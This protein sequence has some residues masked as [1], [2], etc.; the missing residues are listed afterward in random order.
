M[1]EFDSVIPPGG[2]G[3]VVAKVRTRSL[4]GRRTKS[5]RVQTND[6]A[7]SML[8]LQLSINV[9]A[10]IAVLPQSQLRLTAYVGEVAETAVI[11]RRS[12]GKP[13]VLEQPYSSRK[14]VEVKLEE[15][16]A[17]LLPSIPD[18]LGARVGDWR[19]SA[20]YADTAKM[21]SESGSLRVRTNHPERAQLTIPVRIN[22]RELV[23]AAP[24]RMQVRVQ[25]G[26]APLV[27]SLTLHHGK[28]ERFEVERVELE[29]DLPGASVE[30]KSSGASRVHRAEVRIDP[31]ELA[32]GTFRGYL[33]ATLSGD[34]KPVRVLVSVRVTP[35]KKVV[36]ANAGAASGQR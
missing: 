8:N 19:V 34:Y 15:I 13:L 20:R 9:V 32:V 12:D 26:V 17:E 14:A 36:P 2:T 24:R 7:Q 21:R 6:P 1:A 27:R 29:G 3:K 11:V 18:H 23:S 28:R 33:V 10:A 35:P 5:V 16:T 30:M 22:I 4:Q 31:R 25:Q